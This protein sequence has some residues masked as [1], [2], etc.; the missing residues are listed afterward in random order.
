MDELDDLDLR[1]NPVLM[2]IDDFLEGLGLNDA[3]RAA[4]WRMYNQADI[5]MNRAGALV[6]SVWTWLCNRYGTWV[7]LL[8][9]LVIILAGLPI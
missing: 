4:W 7:V 8:T 6:A 1:L 2:G 5:M 9:I 3:Q